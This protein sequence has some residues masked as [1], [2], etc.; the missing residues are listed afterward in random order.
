MSNLAANSFRHNPSSGV[1]GSRLQVVGSA[2]IALSMLAGG[3]AD[4]LPRSS[5]SAT[6]PVVHSNSIAIE[7]YHRYITEV[8]EED[9]AEYELLRSIP[10]DFEYVEGHPVAC[11][12]EGGVSF[13]FSGVDE[14]DAV[15]HL[16]DWI[17]G[18]HQ[19]LT[20]EVR[21]NPNALG[22]I[23]AQQLVVLNDYLRRRE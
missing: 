18:T 20:E 23:P 17:I 22:P 6:A 10:V 1:D 11:F 2:L 12:R 21:R 5:L 8:P 7:K 4:A 14:E 3:E 16:I 15:D 9:A 19:S 13:S